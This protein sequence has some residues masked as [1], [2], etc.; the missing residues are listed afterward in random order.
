M[1]HDGDGD[2]IWGNPV[3]GGYGARERLAEGGMGV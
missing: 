1:S 3:T 2:Q